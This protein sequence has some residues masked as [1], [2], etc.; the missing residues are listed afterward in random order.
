MK[1]FLL[2]NLNFCRKFKHSLRKETYLDCRKFIHPSAERTYVEDKNS[3]PVKND[4]TNKIKV[5]SDDIPSAAPI[6]SDTVSNFPLPE[7]ADVLELDYSEV[8]N[9]DAGMIY[10]DSI[11]TGASTNFDSLDSTDKLRE[12][13]TNDTEKQKYPASFSEIMELVQKGEQIPGV[14]DLNIEPTNA[15]PTESVKPPA[16]KPWES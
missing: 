7:G 3:S 11:V 14:L 10:G 8:A 1:R 5:T 2:I 16:K 6:V 15:L 9:E 13:S 12:V 4:V